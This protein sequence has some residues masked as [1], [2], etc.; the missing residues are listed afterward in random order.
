[1]ELHVSCSVVVYSDQGDLL[2]ILDKP[3]SYYLKCRSIDQVLKLLRVV[4]DTSW[5]AE[6]REEWAAKEPELRDKEV[7][8]LERR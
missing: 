7:K 4:V 3:E 5:A 6:I 2:E 1:M 8:A